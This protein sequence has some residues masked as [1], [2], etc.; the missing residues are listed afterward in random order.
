MIIEVD[1]VDYCYEKENGYEFPFSSFFLYLELRSEK[2][3]VEEVQYK[4]ILN[5]HWSFNC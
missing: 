2:E 3:L 1:Q 4:K 5:K